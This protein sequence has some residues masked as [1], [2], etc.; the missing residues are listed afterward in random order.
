MIAKKY[1]YI[2]CSKKSGVPTT[3]GEKGKEL[4]RETLLRGKKRDSMVLDMN[5]EV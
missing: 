1:I 2:H 5:T 4:L 3:V